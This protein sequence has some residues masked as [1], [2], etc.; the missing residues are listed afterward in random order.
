[1][2]CRDTERSSCWPLKSW[3]ALSHPSQAMVN[4]HISPPPLFRLPVGLLPGT[5]FHLP[6]PGHLPLS[7]C[8][9]HFQS[10]LGKAKESMIKQDC[11]L[12]AKGHGV[13]ETSANKGVIAIAY[14]RKT[15]SFLLGT[16]SRMAC[17]KV[18]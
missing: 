12:G 6:D 8:N 18:Q 1:M 9:L 4:M 10:I 11:L 14:W 3:T 2:W 5:A 13:S 17:S 7:I 15:Q 16:L